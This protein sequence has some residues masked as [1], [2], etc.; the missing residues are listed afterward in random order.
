MITRQPT[1]CLAA[2][3][4]LGL[5]GCAGLPDQQLARQAYAMGDTATAERH[6][7]QLAELGYSDAS[8]GL[9]DIQLASG[10]PEQ[11]R[12]A[13]QTYRQAADQS[14]RAQARLGRL[15]AS[16]PAASEAERREAAELLENALQH[17]ESS[18]LMPLAM[19]YLQYPQ[20]WPQVNAQQRIDTWRRQGHAQADLA[21][22]LVY[23]TQGSYAEHLDEVEQ[24]CRKGL[25]QM[26]VCYVELATVYQMRGQ[27]EQQQTLIEQL[28]SA[29]RFAG[30]PPERLE[31][32]AQVLADGEL[33]KPDEATAQALLESIAEQYPPAWVSLAR[34]LYDYPA[35]GDSEQ[36][37]DYLKRGQ[38]A[39]QPRADLLLG[40]LY[41]EGKWLP[42]DPKAA[43]THLLKAATS[44]T[45]AHYFLGQL[46]RRGYLGQVYP[47]KAV[48]HLITAARR[49]Q[50]SA[51]FA[52]AQLYSQGRGIRPNPVNAYAFATL[53]IQVENPHA[54][55]LKNLLEGQLS[56][57]EKH[58]AQ[59]LVQRE[60]Q[61][62]NRAWQHGEATALTTAEPRLTPQD[63]L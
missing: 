50:I 18:A 32:V 46:Y 60:L 14:P 39:A 21:Q 22:I 43:E 55:E 45:S 31:A 54:I 10:D 35:L 29:Y 12:Q 7:R 28:R 38:Q 30:V 25:S 59:Q 5:A 33:G 17:G 1:L 3:I 6:F 20:Y 2:A 63:N 53:A 51:D 49:G 23:R 42:Q 56:T 34:L 16:K 27:T 44:E 24:I 11:M 37:F 48:D 9:A 15:L 13:E 52:L 19:L 58:Q 36:M 4:A 47:Q 57:T 41:Y 40:R 61:Q 8:V 62:R 26:D